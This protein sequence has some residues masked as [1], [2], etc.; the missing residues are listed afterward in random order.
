MEILAVK[1]QKNACEILPQKIASDLASLKI[2][3]LSGLE[4][5]SI[6]TWFAQLSHLQELDLNNN[7][8]QQLPLELMAL[9]KLNRINLEQNK[10]KSIP[11]CLTRMPWLNHLA[12]DN[13]PLS[14]EERQLAFNLWGIWF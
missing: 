9:K 8:L 6:P 3:R 2:V 12:L 11:L 7:Q 10:F 5:N 1:C 4:L 13:N 14:E